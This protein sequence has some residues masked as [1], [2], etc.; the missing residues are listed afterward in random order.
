VLLPIVTLSPDAVETKVT[1]SPAAGIDKAVAV[2]VGAMV[3]FKSVPT[4]IVALPY[5]FV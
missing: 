3:M 4:A 1:V 2:T 5:V